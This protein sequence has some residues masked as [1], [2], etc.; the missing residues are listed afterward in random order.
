MASQW[1]EITSQGTRTVHDE[2][3]PDSDVIDAA[4]GCPVSAISVVN[5]A[6]GTVVAP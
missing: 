5:A 3:N 1:F 2:L 4:E 6:D